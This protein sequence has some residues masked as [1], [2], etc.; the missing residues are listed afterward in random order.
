MH[1]D[2]STHPEQQAD[3]NDFEQVTAQTSRIGGSAHWKEVVR[4]PY[5]GESGLPY[6]LTVSYIESW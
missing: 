6:V 1:H 2:H 5:Y 4:L 3:Q